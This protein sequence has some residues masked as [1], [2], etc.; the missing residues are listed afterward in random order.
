MEHRISVYK[1][2]MESVKEI[3]PDFLQSF[4]MKG[5]K[6]MGLTEIQEMPFKH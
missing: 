4:L 6:A 1:Y 2:L 3:G 5:L